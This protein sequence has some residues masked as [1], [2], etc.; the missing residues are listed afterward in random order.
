[1]A[2]ITAKCYH[3]LHWVRDLL[4]QFQLDHTMI[5]EVYYIAYAKWCVWIKVKLEFEAPIGNTTLRIDLCD[6]FY[7]C[8]C[9]L[10]CIHNFAL[11]NIARL[12]R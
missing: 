7:S 6:F 4:P 11:S 9:N 1:M 12:H 10:K 2:L 5:R 8:H 3:T